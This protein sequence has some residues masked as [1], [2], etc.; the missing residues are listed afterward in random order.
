MDANVAT[1]PGQTGLFRGLAA[2]SGGKIE[3]GEVS[4]DSLEVPQK[5]V[6][7]PCFTPKTLVLLHFF[8][9]WRV[10]VT[11]TLRLHKPL[12]LVSTHMT[13]TKGT[14][15]PRGKLCGKLHEKSASG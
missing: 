2:W 10:Q 5:M 7:L 1:P 6:V 14:L 3:R 4:D 11:P 12:P 9:I 13:V 8:L 15:G